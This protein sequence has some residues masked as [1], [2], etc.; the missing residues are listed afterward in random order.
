MG[1]EREGAGEGSAE[2]DKREEECNE[3]APEGQQ[4]ERWRLSVSMKY[5]K[6]IS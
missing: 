4:N 3:E 1:N 2:A 5:R 6:C